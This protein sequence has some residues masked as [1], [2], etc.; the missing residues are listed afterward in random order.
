MEKKRVLFIS[1]EITPYIPENEISSIGRNLPEGIMESG[2]D[3]LL[4]TSDAA[5]DP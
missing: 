2:K 1:Q 3:C 4:Y 5:D